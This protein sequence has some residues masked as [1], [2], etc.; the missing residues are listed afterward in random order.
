MHT[1]LLPF[2]GVVRVSGEDRSTFLHGQLS[3]H[4][5]NLVPGLAGYSTYNTP[6]GRVIADMLVI[7]RED[8]LLLLMAK[9]LTEKTV[10]R[11]K[12][13]VLRAKVQFE[14]LE[15]WGV[16]GETEA[17]LP[18]LPA[19]S[20][21]YTFPYTF[22]DGII[23]LPL[24]HQGCLKIGETAKLP[25]FDGQAEQ[26]W[27][28]HEI[29]SGYAWISADTGETAVAQMLNQ[30][31]IG[32]VHFKKGCYPGQ[33]IIARAQYRGQVKRGLALLQTTTPSAV[34]STIEDAD[35][36]EA[37][38]VLNSVADGPNALNLAVLKHSA[39]ETALNILGN[40]ATVV[41]TFF[42]SNKS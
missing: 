42:P 24:P 11:L 20:P 5:K 40:P 33:E 14:I 16:A 18:P 9:D 37:G 8:D 13:F 10:K 3:N 4:I 30:H 36:N 6:K 35:G 2:F 1:S 34:G 32:G 31:I 26:V 15:N 41:Q 12:M 22:A 27:Q 23:T 7:A 38:I 17:G 28:A 25:A 39:A 21:Q 19:E 29:R